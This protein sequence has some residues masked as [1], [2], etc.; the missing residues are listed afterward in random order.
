MKRF[1]LVL[2]VV[3]ATSS[4]SFAGGHHRCCA[5]C[6][7]TSGLR[8]VCRWECEV[9]EVTVPGW[10]C[11]C[12]DLVIPGKSSYCIKDDCDECGDSCD[13]CRTCEKHLGGCLHH[14]KEW[15][16]PCGCCVKTVKVLVRTEKTVKKKIWKPV[17]E[18]VC[19]SCCNNGANGSC[20]SGGYPAGPMPA[21]TDMPP[22]APTLA[23][24]DDT[25]APMPPMPEASSGRPTSRR[26]INSFLSAFAPSTP[27]R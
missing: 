13:C 26:G 18:T 7:C 11:E 1:L 6:G 4:S 10:D 12:E 19:D 2:S 21:A 14:K 24:Q 5:D 27:Q 15:G 23:P 3:L 8:K 9:V 22:P 17:I 16:P 20:A 25:K